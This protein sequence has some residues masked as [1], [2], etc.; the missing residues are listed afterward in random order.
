MQDK[1]E[2]RKYAKKVRKSLDIPL[3][4]EKIVKKIQALDVY[5]RAKNVMIFYP[6]E[7]EIDLTPLFEDDKKF[8]LPKVTGD[9]LSVCPYTQ[10]DKLV[11]SAF[12]TLEPL[13]EAVSAQILDVIFVPALMADKFN[14]RLGY[15]GGF[16]D[17]F[18]A[19]CPP[20]TVKIVAVPSALIVDEIPFESFDIKTDITI[21]E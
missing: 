9:N 13:T 20:R 12:N 4:S 17:R 10:E 3:I 6:L 2:L 5:K 1:K 18:L 7:F 15:G 8:F 16:Y 19:Q 14:N 11:I 21:C